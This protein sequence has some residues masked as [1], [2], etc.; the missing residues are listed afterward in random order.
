MR[1]TVYI[2][3]ISNMIHRAFYVHKDLST[4]YGFSTGAIWGTTHMLLNF[5]KKYK[6][7][8]L[9]V[10]YDSQNG[11]SLRKDMY[12]LYKANRTQVTDVSAE[13]KIIRRIIE[14]LGISSVS[15]EG[16][17]A[18][19][20]IAHT[21]G[22]F[23]GEADVVVV[24][25]DKDLMQLVEDRVSMLDTMKGIRYFPKDVEDKFGVR[26]EQLTDY[27]ALVGDSSDN[28]PGVQGIGPKGAVD[29][30]K[31]HNDIDSIYSNLNEQTPK[32]IEKL[33]AGK[34]DAMLSRK[35][36]QFLPMDMNVSVEDTKL[37]P[38]PNEKIFDLFTKLEF[39]N[40]RYDVELMWQSYRK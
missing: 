28:I 25:G 15:L 33:T 9:L 14:L 11:K 2:I 40:I 39:K 23:K 18:D 38:T 34:D 30:L 35:L 20:L 8:H 17:E 13:E 10:C 6:P 1:N 26:P 31:K 21:S 27:L 36:V 5:I 24:S 32:M 16:Y 3:D 4:S 12:P 37:N 22:L 7:T 29:L 19:D